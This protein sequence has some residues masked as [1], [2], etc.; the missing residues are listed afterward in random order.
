MSSPA[1]LLPLFVGIVVLS[2]LAVLWWQRYSDD[3][4]PQ[5]QTAA[6]A[7]PGTLMPVNEYGMEFVSIPAGDFLMG[8]TEHEVG[9][10]FNAVKK[11]YASAEEI[12]LQPESPKHR[13]VISHPFE[14]MR[15]EVTQGQWERVTGTTIRQQAA[16]SE[17][18][19]PGFLE[20]EAYPMHSVSWEDVQRFVE[21]LN[22]Q[23]DG[24]TYRLPT[25][26]EWEYAARAGTTTRYY[27]GNDWDETQV[28][29]YANVADLAAREEN[30]QRATTNCLDGYAQEAP[31]GSFVPNGWGLYDMSGNVY[32]W[33][34]DWWAQDYYEQS[35]STDPS[36]PTSGEA[37]GRRGGGW[38]Y[39]P[40]SLRSAS[41]GARPPD[42]RTGSIGFRLA[43]T[44]G[45]AN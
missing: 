40:P 13:V 18:T 11:Y 1:K 43:R 41:R 31:V 35:P 26:A 32:E 19:R 5:H 24:Y 6:S 27:W 14:M 15:Y 36:G 7:P 8:S 4:L 37:R 20:G 16:K 23:R 3:A 21:R 17:R 29:R 28:C 44:R 39:P 33:V 12:W 45:N 30:P 2:L 42:F 10:A 22:E 34:N 38:G 25:E 9:E